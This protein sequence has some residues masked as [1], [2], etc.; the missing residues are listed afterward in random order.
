M[1]W[2]CPPGECEKRPA[3]WITLQ[4]QCQYRIIL[5]LPGVSEWLEHF[6][7]QLSCGSLNVF[8][9]EE[10]ELARRDTRREAEVLAPLQP[11]RFDHFDWW[12]P[13]LQSGVHYVHVTVKRRSPRDGR[14]VC[15]AIQAALSELDARP[16]RARCIAERGQQLARSLTMEAVY[17]YTAEVLR[18][19]AAAQR[20]EVVQRQVTEVASM[21]QH[22]VTKRNMLR[23]VSASTRPWIE[24][25]FL[26][27]N[28]RPPNASAAAGAAVPPRDP[29]RSFTFS[30]R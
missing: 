22:V 2:K 8:V 6:K 15:A 26:P 24:R 7:H 23:H 1:A 14:A 30:R 27:S 19:A 16:G 9:T 3:R 5:H 20:P 25:I 18:R 11:P 29:K 21:A 4:E 10:H 17:K 28:G 13:L 12:A